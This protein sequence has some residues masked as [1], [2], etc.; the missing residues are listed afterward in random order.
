MM[1][2]ENFPFV[3]IDMV[4]GS[5][6]HDP[7]LEVFMQHWLLAFSALSCLNVHVFLKIV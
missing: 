3:A 1:V 7:S 6:L 2:F 5:W 4:F